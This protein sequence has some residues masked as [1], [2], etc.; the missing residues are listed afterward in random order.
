MSRSLIAMIL[1]TAALVLGGGGSSAPATEL[2]LQLVFAALI[3]L[4]A[5]AGLRS[6]W[7]S[8]PAPAVLTL[9]ALVLGLP[10]LQLIPLPPALWQSLPG[11]GVEAEALALIG[12]ENAWMPWS[13]TPAR[14]LASLMAMIVPVGLFVVATGLPLERR[15]HLLLVVVGGALASAVLGALQLGAGQGSAWRLYSETHLLYITGF[16]ANRNATADLILIALLAL[17]AWW[18]STRSAPGIGRRIAALATAALLTLTLVLTG[19]R[20]GIALLA[21]VAILAL[22][23]LWSSLPS[24]ESRAVR[25]AGSAGVLSLLAVGAA[26]LPAFQP[27]VKRFVEAGD[28]RW[29]L[30]EDTRQAIAVHW[31]AGSGI[32]SFQ[33]VFI[34]QER[35]EFVD[36]SMPVR[37]HNDWLEFTLEAGLAGWLVLAAIAGLL[38]FQAW[39]RTG[40]AAV[41]DE[42]VL[43]L[44]GLGTLAVVALHSLVDY[45][46]RTMTLACLAALGAAMLFSPPGATARAGINTD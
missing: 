36:P 28:E 40:R 42:R 20:M 29:K 35:L 39:R 21:P 3:A 4:A 12:A 5:L 32:G 22:A 1:L 13:L 9:A 41:P 14:T 44:F 19:S 43:G 26:R 46:F 30:W 38:G 27:V 2:A 37:A 8:A 6:G 25:I 7:P 23:I 33:P 34:A 11:R 31:P 18:A 24:G 10:L 15:R 45:P 16:F 17:A